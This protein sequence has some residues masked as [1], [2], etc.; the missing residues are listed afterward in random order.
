[1]YCNHIYWFTLFSRRFRSL[2][3]NTSLGVFVE[4][5]VL[6]HIKY[7]DAQ[8]RHYVIWRSRKFIGIGMFSFPGQC[9]IS[10]VVSFTSTLATSFVTSWINW[11]I[12]ENRNPCC[13]TCS[14]IGQLCSQMMS[15]YWLSSVSRM[16]E[17][18]NLE[19]NVFLTENGIQ[20][21]WEF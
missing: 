21:M 2:V 17:A 13:A 7:Y 18:N 9:F 6:C 8:R 5:V 19:N 1:M 10:M 14:K 15:S 4:G 12:K 16:F 3:Q 11:K 20:D